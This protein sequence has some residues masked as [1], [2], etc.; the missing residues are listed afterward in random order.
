MSGLRFNLW[1]TLLLTLSSP[2]PGGDSVPPSLGLTGA[3]S[4]T[5]NH[6]PSLASGTLPVI[7]IVIVMIVVVVVVLLVDVGVVVSV[8]HRAVDLRAGAVSNGW[9]WRGSARGRSTTSL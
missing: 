7:I 4:L 9:R 6:H 5:G 3:F 8:T 1:N 2:D